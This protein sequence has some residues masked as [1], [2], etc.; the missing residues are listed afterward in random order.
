[1]VLPAALIGQ[2]SSLRPKNVQVD[3]RVNPFTDLGPLKFEGQ[4]AIP[5][6]AAEDAPST[7]KLVRT[8]QDAMQD[9]ETTGHLGAKVVLMIN[10]FKS[11]SSGDVI[12]SLSLQLRRPVSILGTTEVIEATVASQEGVGRV[13]SRQA[14]K[15]ILDQAKEMTRSLRDRIDAAQ[16][17]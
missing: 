11:T 6:K 17:D 7:E 16:K 8:V 1:M 12:Y 14:E 4:L 13:P 5:G 3:S 2:E 9:F 10:S 15:F